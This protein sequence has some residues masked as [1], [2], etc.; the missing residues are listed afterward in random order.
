[1]PR[2]PRVTR[3]ALLAEKDTRIASFERELVERLADKD[4]RIADKERLLADKERL[5]ADNEARHAIVLA[6][7][8]H[9]AAV[10][11]GQLS[12]RSVLQDAVSSA[13]A[14]CAP[15]RSKA[16]GVGTRIEALLNECPGFVAYL[17]VAAD[18]N[19]VDP[20][21]VLVEAGKLYATLCLRSHGDTPVSSAA[22][23]SAVFDNLGDTALVAY[24]GIVHF[25]GRRISL[26]DQARTA[27]P[28][29]MRTEHG[30][31]ATEATIRRS[32]PLFEERGLASVSAAERA[33]CRCYCNVSLLNLPV[34]PP[35][36]NAP[37]ASGC[38]PSP[39]L[40]AASSRRPLASAQS[41]R[42][43]TNS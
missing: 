9:A 18:D 12:V 19:S 7:A 35:Y 28:L 34:H 24:A 33:R 17:R 43:S 15:L 38:P 22:L 3:G 2:A 8:L 11:E 37:S 26:Y 23:S 25:S 41:E 14:A 13:W 39:P 16:Q 29:V 42:R 40:P 30:C 21:G 20:E 36:F 32:L 10:A 4:A 5:F 31:R 27:L 1:M 6:A